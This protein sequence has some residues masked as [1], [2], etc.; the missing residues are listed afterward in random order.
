MNKNSEKSLLKSKSEKRRSESDTSGKGINLD[1]I[2]EADVV[3]ENC[4]LLIIKRKFVWVELA[5]SPA[6]TISLSTDVSPGLS[7]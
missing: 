6:K 5:P 2:I 7:A 1:E 3:E 4:P